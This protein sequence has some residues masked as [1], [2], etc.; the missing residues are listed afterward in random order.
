M[1]RAGGPG[2][3]EGL[4]RWLLLWPPAP[5]A[6]RSSTAPLVALVR[7]RATSLLQEHLLHAYAQ[8]KYPKCIGDDM[9]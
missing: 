4:V 7:T 6:P 9:A 2:T 5:P 8:H 1:R 3:Q